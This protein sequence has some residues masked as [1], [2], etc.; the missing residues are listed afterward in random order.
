MLKKSLKITISLLTVASAVVSGVNLT[1]AE[2]F[3]RC[4]TQLTD[5]RL[6]LGDPRLAQIM[7]KRLTPV[8]ACMD[9]IEAAEFGTDGKIPS[10]ESSQKSEARQV[11]RKMNKVHSAFFRVDDFSTVMGLRL[12]EDI[13]DVQTPAYYYTRAL[14]QPNLNFTT[15]VTSPKH[16]RAIR[17]DSRPE[18]GIIT[19]LTRDK[20]SFGNAEVFQPRGDLLGIQELASLTLGEDLSNPPVSVDLAS[21]YGGGILGSNHYNFLIQSKNQPI[22]ADGGL[23]VH[24]GFAKSVMSD[25]LCR[26]FPVVEEKDVRSWVV[27]TSNLTFRTSASCVQCHASMDQLAGLVRNLSYRARG[28]RD[29]KDP[30]KNLELAYFLFQHPT[31]QS[32]VNGWPDSATPNYHRTPA[33]GRLFYRN[34]ANQ[35]IN[36][37]VRD[38]PSLGV[39]LSQQF[40]LY[41]CA[42]SRYYS[43]FTG[44]NVKLMPGLV[45]SG[46][47]P[48]GLLV[49]A[50]QRP[51]VQNIIDLAKG[52]E[53]NQ[54]LKAMIESIFRLPEYRKS[55]FGVVDP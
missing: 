12:I 53:S 20:V 55:D 24:R 47:A 42:A 52:L 7:A 5:K 32:R 31:D 18:K 48:N 19:G 51:H 21:H 37:E 2:L 17:T 10:A 30:T 50:A 16:L 13:Y 49:N 41:L 36:L 29:P 46:R 45:T 33:E 9:L 15:I 26:E 23:Q 43:Y 54:S 8:A 11:L 44:V 39:A 38:L 1:D 25:F 35:L 22:T 34:S 14:F 3:Q 28:Q 27:P 4:Y 40:D 6:D